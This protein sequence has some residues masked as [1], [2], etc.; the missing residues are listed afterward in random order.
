MLFRSFICHGLVDCLIAH[1]WLSAVI[2]G[3]VIVPICNVIRPGFSGTHQHRFFTP[4]FLFSRCFFH[5]MPARTADS[6]TLINNMLPLRRWP[7]LPYNKSKSQNMATTFNTIGIIGKHGAPNTG[8]V[9]KELLVYLQQRQISV[10]LD[11]L[12]LAADNQIGRA[13]V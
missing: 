7:R 3:I 13:H 12:S 5:T 2:I 1:C 10:L 6:W 4:T 9:L 8:G 11:S